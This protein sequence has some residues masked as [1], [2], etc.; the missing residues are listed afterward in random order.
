MLDSQIFLGNWTS[1]WT[2]SSR[3]V[4]LSRIP[5]IW[6]P[7]FSFSFSL[8]SAS[9]AVPAEKKDAVGE[10]YMKLCQLCWGSWMA[11]S[12]PNPTPSVSSSRFR[13]WCWWCLRGRTRVA[14]AGGTARPLR[15]WRLQETADSINCDSDDLYRKKTPV[16]LSD[17][18]VKQ[19][20]DLDCV[21]SMRT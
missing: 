4:F 7:N 21:D 14:T 15:Q 1:D 12:Q 16:T 11:I 17:S 6:A 3:G 10:N 9:S 8:S 20:R 13:T 19:S 5:S 2:S 18:K